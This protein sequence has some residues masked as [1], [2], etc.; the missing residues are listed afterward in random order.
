MSFNNRNTKSNFE[1]NNLYDNDNNNEYK[2]NIY[3][4]TKNM[5]KNIIKRKDIKIINYK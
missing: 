2:Q 4:P 3:N 5:K 1:L